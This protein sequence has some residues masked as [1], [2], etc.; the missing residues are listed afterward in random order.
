MK[1][2]TY[3]SLIAAAFASA[4]L[5]SG[6]ATLFTGTSQEVEVDSTPSDASVMVNGRERGTTPTTIE[7]TSPKQG[8]PPE[9]T[10]DKEGY[11]EKTLRLKKK[12]NVITLLN[13][14]NPFNYVLGV[15][16]VGFGVDWYTGALWKYKPEGYTVELKNGTMSSMAP[17]PSERARYELTNLPTDEHGHH[18]VPSHDSAVSVYDSETGT[19]YTFR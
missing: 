1:T 13:V 16:V 14:I 7:I 3:L 18:V 19:V 2:S 15:P 5:L 17:R 8:D 9:V 12:F 6:C 4:L 10:I 11:E